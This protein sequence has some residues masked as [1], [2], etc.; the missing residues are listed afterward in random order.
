MKVT[1]D[2]IIWTKKHAIPDEGVRCFIFHAQSASWFCFT[3]VVFCGTLCVPVA[4][5]PVDSQADNFPDILDGDADAVEANEGDESVQDAEEEDDENAEQDIDDADAG[6][7]DDDDD[8]E[9]EDDDD[10]LD[11][12]QSREIRQELLQQLRGQEAE[13]HDTPIA[14]EDKGPALRTFAELFLDLDMYVLWKITTPPLSP[15]RDVICCWVVL[16]GLFWG[17]RG[18]STSLTQRRSA[19]NFNTSLSRLIARAG[20]YECKFCCAPSSSPSP[21]HECVILAHAFTS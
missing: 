16:P 21:R 12:R 8:G 2:W 20:R 5:F 6:D 13:D 11:K 15:T 3:L 7:N 19:S 10:E 14:G 1:R 4:A 18:H 9:D 17:G